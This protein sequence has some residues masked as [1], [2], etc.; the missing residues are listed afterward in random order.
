MPLVV[1]IKVDLLHTTVSC[2]FL[3]LDFSLSLPLCLGVLAYKPSGLGLA[4][5]ACCC[6]TFIIIDL[7]EVAK[8]RNKFMP[9]VNYS[10]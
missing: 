10:T 2:K 9:N 6:Y 7:D 4:V 1:A 5:R 3:I 8:P